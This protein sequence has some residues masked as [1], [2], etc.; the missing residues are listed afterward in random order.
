MA[1]SGNKKKSIHGR[2]PKIAHFKAKVMHPDNLIGKR[3]SFNALRIEEAHPTMA[4]PLTRH[5]RRYI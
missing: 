1:P 5:D 4:S 3:K 2:K